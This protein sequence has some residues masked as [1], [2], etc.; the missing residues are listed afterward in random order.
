MKEECD[1]KFSLNIN[2]NADIDTIAYFAEKC[3]KIIR[4]QGNIEGSFYFC[5]SLTKKESSENP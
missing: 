4:N 3:I 2:V 5:R 1:L